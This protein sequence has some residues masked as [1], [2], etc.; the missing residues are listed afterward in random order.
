MT[1][2]TSKSKYFSLLPSAAHFEM[3]RMTV[4]F[5]TKSMDLYTEEKYNQF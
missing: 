5:D 2:L 1:Y 3:M 4:N